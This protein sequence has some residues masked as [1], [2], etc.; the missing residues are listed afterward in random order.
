MGRHRDPGEK[1]LSFFFSV[2]MEVPGPGMEFEPK[3]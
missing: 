3:L 1:I 2:H